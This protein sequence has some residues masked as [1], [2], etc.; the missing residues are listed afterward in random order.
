MGFRSTLDLWDAGTQIALEAQDRSPVPSSQGR[1]GLLS[2]WAKVDSLDTIEWDED[3]FGKRSAAVSVGEAMKVPAVKKGR[4]IL[5]AVLTSSPLVAI[6]RD[7]ETGADT[8]L[9]GKAAPTWLGRSDTGIAP[10]A[11]MGSILD[12]HLFH[13]GA[14]LAVRRGAIPEGQT[15]GPILDAVHL[16]YSWWEIDPDTGLFLVDEQPVDQDALVYIPG[17]SAGLLVE[18]RGE[19][20]QWLDIAR[21]IAT[22]L[23]TPVPPIMLQDSETGDVDDDEMDKWVAKI[24]S[25]RRKG[26][27]MLIPSGMTGTAVPLNDDSAMYI[28]SRNA[29]RI[30]LANHMNLP[31]ALLDGSPATASLTYSTNEGK[32]SEFDDMSLDYWTT[33]IEAAL[34]QDN[35]VPRGTRVRFDFTSRFAPAN[36]PTGAPTPD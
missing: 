17:P 34:S 21:N 9:V 10:E 35:V 31:V 33:P 11:R 22:R 12:D 6:R 13:E 16:P 15:R 26:G 7:Q 14:L 32:R 20:R 3:T 8:T 25:Q 4:G 24:A 30:D 1:V 2:P 28:A 19:I 5:Q 27:V 23:A 36:A 29:L 18:A